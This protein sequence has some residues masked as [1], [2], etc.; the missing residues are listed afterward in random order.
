METSHVNI[1][2]TMQ[3]KHQLA[4]DSEFE[5]CIKALITYN[6]R[7]CKVWLTYHKG[8]AN[9]RGYWLGSMIDPNYKVANST[10]NI[11]CSDPECTLKMILAGIK[12]ILN[13]DY[14]HI[15]GVGF[16]TGLNM[17]DYIT[18]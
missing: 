7:T 14:S 13:K 5:Y 10:I 16:V 17:S 8:Y 18:L 2:K 6:G 1:N 4:F 3:I 15:Q 12:A 9:M 11:G